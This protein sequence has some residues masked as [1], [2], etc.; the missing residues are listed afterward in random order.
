M[1]RWAVIREREDGAW[2]LFRDPVH[3]VWTTRTDEVIPLLGWVEYQTQTH[4]LYAVGWVAYDAAPAMDRALKVPGQG[5]VPLMCFGLF[6]A[7]VRLTSAR[8]RPGPRVPSLSWTPALSET[9]YVSRFNR[10]KAYIADGHTYQ[11]NFTFPLRAAWQGDPWDLFTHLVRAQ[12]LPYG[13]YLDAGRYVVCSASPE[14]FFALEGDC[15]VSRP[16]KGTAPRGRTWEEDVERVRALRSSEKERAE[17]VMIVDMVRNDLGR[18]A[19]LGSVT[20]PALCTVERYPTVWQMTSTV[21]ARTEASVVSIFRHLFP[22]A[23]VTGAP[24]VRTMEI[25]AQLEVAPRGVYTGAIGYLAPRRRA[26]FNVAIRTVVIDRATATAVYSVGSGVVWDS[27]PHREYQECLTKARVLSTVWPEFQLLTSLLWEPDGGYFLLEAHMRRL[28]RSA[29][30]FGF[31]WPEAA[32]YR[33]L[34]TL[35]SRWPPVPH[36]VRVLLSQGG[37]IRVE[38]RPLTHRPKPLRVGIARVP[39]DPDDP[40]LY[41]KTTHR[42]VYERA[43]A[44]C[45]TCDD[46]LLWNSRG[47][48]TEATIANVVL[49]LDGEW[50][51]PPVDSGLLPGVFRE[52][53][54]Q[55]GKIRERVIPLAEL[56]RAEAVYLINSVRRW[57]PARLVDTLAPLARASAGSR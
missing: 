5:T 27:D 31:P 26:Q 44:D 37:G 35:P 25:I 52:W 30:Y 47:E 55:Q 13:A 7:P 4:E 53:L 17:N 14:L 20:V 38:G 49:R 9:D 50:V 43:R 8:L 16:M 21:T 40:F 28:A 6:R 1:L 48:L 24:K 46:V 22:A 42:V 56:S 11:V 2:W 39:V 33:A 29:E 36:K 15:L 18:I 54:L 12:D 19:R 10:I 51:T 41:H 3:V 34:H 23:S 32:L 45:P 57:M